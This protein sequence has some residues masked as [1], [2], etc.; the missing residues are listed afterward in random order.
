MFGFV[1]TALIAIVPGFANATRAPSAGE[2][3]AREHV[4][5]S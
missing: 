3:A 1:G 4:Y 2:V 5:H